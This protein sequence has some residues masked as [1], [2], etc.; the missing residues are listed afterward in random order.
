MSNL[1][2]TVL[3]VVLGLLSSSAIAAPKS[4]VFYCI[5]T[6]P[7]W[8]LKV[9]PKGIKLMMPV[10]EIETTR[11]AAAAPSTFHGYVPDF[12]KIYRTRSATSDATIII[13]P[14]A[15][16]SDDMS[17]ESY[18][19]SVI[20]MDSILGDMHGCCNVAQE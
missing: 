16:C 15:S 1:K 18:S 8:S 3:S 9:H 11:Y 5:G 10:D 17:E 14:D 6:E 12:G 19:H 20:F 4:D 7:F 2:I 13:Q